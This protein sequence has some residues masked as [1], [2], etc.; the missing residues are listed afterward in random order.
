MRNN[1]T[2]FALLEACGKPGCPVC[3]LEQ[4]ATE[5]YLDHLFYE[6]VNDSGTRSQLRDS[7][8]FCREHTELLLDRGLGDALG[9]SIIYHDVLGSVLVE[10]IQKEMLMAFTSSDG[11]C[12]PHLRQECN[13]VHDGSV[14]VDLLKV[15]VEMLEKLNAELAE[16]IRKS[17]YRYLKDGFGSEGDAWQRASRLSASRWIGKQGQRLNKPTIDE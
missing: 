9:M 10:N 14:L 13:Q 6:N 11:L 17:D 3:Q 1:P 2:Y 7:L 4:Q 5:R 16:Y 8:G 12:L 15:G